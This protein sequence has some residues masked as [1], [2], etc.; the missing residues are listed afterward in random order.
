MKAL[1]HA[2]NSSHHLHVIV[3]TIYKYNRNRITSKE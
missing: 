2:E 1:Q 3:L